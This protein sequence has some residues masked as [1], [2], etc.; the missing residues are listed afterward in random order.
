MEIRSCSLE[1][2][3]ALR[4]QWPTPG[5]DIHGAH[6]AAQQRGTATYLVAW[7]DGKPLGSGMVQWE[8]CVGRNAA[9]AYPGCVEVNHLQVRAEERGKGVGSGL[10]SAGEAMIRSRGFSEA[11]VGVGLDNE[12]AA[13]LYRRLGYEQTGVRDVTSYTWVD[14][15]GTAHD[16]TEDD[17][18]LVKT[19][20]ARQKS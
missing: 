8:G 1:D 7:R 6:F 2:L 14:A 5:S 20:V 11:A 15:D 13:R 3:G 18:L 9:L 16:E 4:A 19:L 12:E 17:E 10:L